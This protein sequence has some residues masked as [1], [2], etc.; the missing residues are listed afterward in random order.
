MVVLRVVVRVVVVVLLVVVVV[1]LVVVGAAALT[2]KTSVPSSA[3]GNVDSLP[4]R[5]V[6][7]T[8]EHPSNGSPC[9]NPNKKKVFSLENFGVFTQI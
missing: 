2:N 4:F 9:R 5:A 8:A 6:L 7:E 3:P 1:L